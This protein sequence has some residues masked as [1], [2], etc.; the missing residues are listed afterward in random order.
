MRIQL[1]SPQ[2]MI[3][4][5]AQAAACAR[6]DDVIA[7]VGELGA[8]KTQFAK[9]FAQGLGI[10][11][12]VTS[13][14]FPIVTEYTG[15]GSSLLHFDLYR[16]ETADQ[17]N[18]IDFFGLLDAGAISL[19]EWGDRFAEALPEDHVEIAIS[20]GSDGVRDLE[21]V[22]KG[23]RGEEFTEDLQAACCQDDTSC[24]GY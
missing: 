19:I 1:A 24:S 3:A 21:I 10:D 2:D 4:F 6:P 11:E 8:G 16:L 15:P 18:D 5:G 22:G 14:T 23:A 7:L 13:P 12:E 20:V 17:L 9:G